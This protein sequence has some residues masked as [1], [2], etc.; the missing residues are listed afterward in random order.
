MK[1]KKKKKTTKRKKKGEHKY[2]EK[3]LGKDARAALQGHD[4]AECKR[5]YEK[6]GL[7]GYGMQLCSRHRAKYKNPETPPGYWGLSMKSHVSVDESC[8][9]QA[10][11]PSQI[12]ED[13]GFSQISEE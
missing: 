11:L 5:F 9:S 4:C 1:K 12:V 7:E 13:E 8:P 10:S 2:T 3:V 6:S